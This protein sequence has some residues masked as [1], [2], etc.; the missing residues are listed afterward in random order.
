MISSGGQL[1]Q[2]AHASLSLLFLL[3]AGCAHSG[4]SPATPPKPSLDTSAVTRSVVLCRTTET[5][6][7]HLL[8]KPTRDGIL[9]KAHIMSWILRSESPVGYLAVLL[10]ERGVVVDLYWDIPTEIPWVPADQCGGRPEGAKG[11]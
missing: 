4:A 11:S 9:H 8:G 6:L 1:R 2:F 7:R 3:V 10:D 5:E